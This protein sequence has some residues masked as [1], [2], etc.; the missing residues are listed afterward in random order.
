MFLMLSSSSSCGVEGSQKKVPDKY[1]NIRKSYSDNFNLQ[2]H[3][4]T[5]EVLITYLNIFTNIS[6]TSDN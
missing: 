6:R 3:I 1:N 4:E 2:L 5:T